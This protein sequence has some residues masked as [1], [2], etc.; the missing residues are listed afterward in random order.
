VLAIISDLGLAMPPANSVDREAHAARIMLLA[1]DCADLPAEHLS[2]AAAEWR[3]TKPYLPKAC[4]LRE[5][6]LTRVRLAMSGRMI[7]APARPRPAAPPSPPLNEAEIRAM[8]TRLLRMGVAI[9]D[10]A[11]E[12]LEERLAVESTTPTRGG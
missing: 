8:P 6:T 9:G 2:A 1:Q 10:I 7:A 12:V 4:E 3:R 5:E 11:P